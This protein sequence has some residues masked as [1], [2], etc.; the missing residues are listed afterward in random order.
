M[1]CRSQLLPF[2]RRDCSLPPAHAGSNIAVKTAMR[3]I[4]NNNSI[5]VKPPR[6]GLLEHFDG[7]AKGGQHPVRFTRAS[8]RRLVN[9]YSH[10]WALM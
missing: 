5:S 8:C 4:T 7:Q 2:A 3:A 6:P 10:G 1:N 9:F